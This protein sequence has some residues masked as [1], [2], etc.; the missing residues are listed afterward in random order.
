M[1]M[2][3]SITR[4]QMSG[5][6]GLRDADKVSVP[7]SGMASAALKTKLMRHCCSWL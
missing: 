1:P 6:D 4:R 5:E 2:P 7:P 3:V